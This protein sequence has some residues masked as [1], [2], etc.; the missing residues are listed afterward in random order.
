VIYA[1]FTSI[2]KEKWTKD[3]VSQEFIRATKWE[4]VSAIQQ[5]IRDICPKEIDRAIDISRSTLIWPPGIEE[6]IQN[7]KRARKEIAEEKR[8]EIYKNALPRPPTDIEIK[9]EQRVEK[10]RQLKIQYPS[11]SWGE[12]G[13]ML[14]ST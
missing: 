14:K 4:W 3:F 12:I 8:N 2:Y 11:L 9:F 7:I 5:E 10:A 1:R 6:F 13:R